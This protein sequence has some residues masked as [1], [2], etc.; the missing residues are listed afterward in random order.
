MLVAPGDAE[1]LAAGLA[2]VMDDPALRQRLAAA[3]PAVV[4]A[5]HRV[6]QMAEAVWGVYEGVLEEAALPTRQWHTDGASR[7]HRAP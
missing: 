5:R 4:A 2:R 1:S 7:T 3:G 6:E